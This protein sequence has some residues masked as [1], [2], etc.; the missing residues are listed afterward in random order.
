M[1]LF[2]QIC[3]LKPWPY[4]MW[5]VM[6]WDFRDVIKSWRW[7]LYEWD[8]YLYKNHLHS[9]C[10][11][12]GK[13]AG[14]RWLFVN[15]EARSHQVLPMTLCLAWPLLEHGPALLG[16]NPYTES[17]H[18]SSSSL[19]DRELINSLCYDLTTLIIWD[20]PTPHSCHLQHGEWNHMM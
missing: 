14:K 7:D 3:M 9:W 6:R 1:L 17:D 11:W 18:A 16:L 10:R 20:L 12:E 8:L 5:C 15:Q 4:L 2:S 19:W 13:D